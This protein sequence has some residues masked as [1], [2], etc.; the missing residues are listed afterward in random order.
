MSILL[1]NC[2]NPQK[3]TFSD[4]KTFFSQFCLLTFQAEVTILKI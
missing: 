3:I 1:K 4:F 2:E